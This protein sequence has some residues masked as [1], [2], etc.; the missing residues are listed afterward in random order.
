MEEQSKLTERILDQ[1]PDAI[2]CANDSG[3]MPLPP[4]LA[5]LPR[6]RSAKVSN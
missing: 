4:C 6:R 5:I 1:A 2:I 3:T